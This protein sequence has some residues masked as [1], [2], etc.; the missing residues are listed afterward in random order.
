MRHIQNL[1]GSIKGFEEYYDGITEKRR[2]CLHDFTLYLQNVVRQ[3]LELPLVVKV[4]FSLKL[5]FPNF[6]FSLEKY[7][8]NIKHAECIMYEL[9]YFIILMKKK[10]KQINKLKNANTTTE[11]I[12]SKDLSTN[13]NVLA[14]LLIIWCKY[15]LGSHIS[16]FFIDDML[17]NNSSYCIR[18]YKGLIPYNATYDKIPSRV[19]FDMIQKHNYILKN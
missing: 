6:T 19:Y 16:I 11:I 1:Y 13:W 12:L 15:T 3:I 7:E 8:E 2:E 14:Q 4:S 18:T 5:F 10:T 17:D 9:Q